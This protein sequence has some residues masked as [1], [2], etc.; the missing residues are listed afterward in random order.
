M[1]LYNVDDNLFSF[2]TRLNQKPMVLFFIAMETGYLPKSP[3]NI[4]CGVLLGPCSLIVS[5]S[6]HFVS[7]N[8]N[9]RFTKVNV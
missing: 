9:F 6:T 3:Y 5:M 1:S 8:H 4:T 7:K 2:E